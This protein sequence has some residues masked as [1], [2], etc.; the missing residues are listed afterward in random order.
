V[1]LK[2]I[3]KKESKERLRVCLSNFRLTPGVAHAEK[4]R[5]GKGVSGHFGYIWRAMRGDV[6]LHMA[7]PAQFS[8]L[9]FRRLTGS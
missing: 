4:T 5:M 8:A 6:F 7:A 1:A 2:R 9:F 3:L